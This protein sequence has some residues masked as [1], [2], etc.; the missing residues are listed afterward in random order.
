M[1][2]QEVLADLREQLAHAAEFDLYAA[3]FDS[4][5]ID[6]AS[7]DSW[8]A[9]QEVPFVETEDLEV[10]FEANP[11]E[12]SLYTAGAMISFSPMGDDLAPM[13]DTADDLDYQASVN[14]D[15][16]ER[17]G[18]SPG[19][20]VLNTFGYHLFG[21]GLL[22]QRGLEQLGAEVF[23]V[24]PG[25]SEQA[26][27]FI[28]E[29]DADALI[30]NP[31]FATKVG[32]E[33]ASVDVFVGGGEPFTSIPGYREE[34]KDALG[35]DTAVDYFGTRHVLPIAAETT[36][37]NGLYVSS[38]YAIVEIVDP[39]TGDPLEP[40]ERGEVVVTHRRKDGF[41]L[42]RYRT[43]DLAELERRGDDLVLPDGVIGRTDNRL[44]VKGV[45]LYPESIPAVLAGFDGLTGEYSL[46]V[47][48]PESTDH[49][50]IRC[51]GSAEEGELA[52]AL[53][54]RLIISPDEVVVVED[55]DRSGVFD[56]RY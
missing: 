19:D 27:A 43:G 33:G 44:K 30:G 9:F 28:Q 45:K 42:V 36:D 12:G 7:I 17:A 14:A 22:V 29:Y 26:A 53:A 49:L 46:T 16:F 23:P 56:E 11:P 25:D 48:R 40:G 51:E 50:E 31:S 35:C 38:E 3:A 13:F 1:Y 41:P 18:I 55:L 24:G 21:T 15:V 10:D 34:V 4:A 37:E 39:D 5:G 2:G 47:T 32:D 52:E 54:D 6:P 8:E 20:R